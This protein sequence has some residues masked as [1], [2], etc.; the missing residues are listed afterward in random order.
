LCP[1]SNWAV[2]EHPRK[3][4]VLSGKN[5]NTSGKNTNTLLDDTNMPMGLRYFIALRWPPFGVGS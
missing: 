4:L 2:R 5:T 1:P 3:L